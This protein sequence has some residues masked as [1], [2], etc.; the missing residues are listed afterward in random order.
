MR[1]K[2]SAELLDRG[3]QHACI[4]LTKIQLPDERSNIRVLEQATEDFV[5]EF[6]SGE[7]D[8][9]LSRVCPSDML[10][11]LCAVLT[12]QLM[13]MFQ[14]LKSMLRTSKNQ[15]FAT[16]SVQRKLA[17]ASIPAGAS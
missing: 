15:S 5:G 1:W 4:G 17:S 14:P 8:E 11:V 10:G 3:F 6:G 7:E 9:S 16:K 2:P 12:T 13:S